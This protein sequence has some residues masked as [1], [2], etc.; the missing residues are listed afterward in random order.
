MNKRRWCAFWTMFLCL[1]G[2]AVLWGC[3]G[4]SGPSAGSQSPCTDGLLFVK[5]ITIQDGTIASPGQSLDKRWQV[6]NSGTCAWGKGYTF[7]L[8]S[9]E[10]MGVASSQTLYPAESG[11][12]A[13]I[14]LVFTAPSIPGFYRSAWQAYNPKGVAFGDPFFME[15]TVESVTAT[16]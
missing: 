5:D 4:S 1:F 11:G 2:Y 9:G 12:Q 16:P 3:T 10:M 8:I 15:I 7:R 13:V 6:Q 14:Q